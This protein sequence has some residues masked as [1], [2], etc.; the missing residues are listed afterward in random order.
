MLTLC[1]FSVSDLCGI[2]KKVI[3]LKLLSTPIRFS[4]IS[5]VLQEEDKIEIFL[6]AEV[7]LEEAN[8]QDFPY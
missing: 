1:I 4:P 7:V 8:T 3:V 5:S 6:D 2:N